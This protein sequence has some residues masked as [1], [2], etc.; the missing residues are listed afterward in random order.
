MT[1]VYSF[2]CNTSISNLCFVFLIFTETD[3]AYRLG[4]IVVYVI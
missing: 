4:K 3:D 1:R 2:P